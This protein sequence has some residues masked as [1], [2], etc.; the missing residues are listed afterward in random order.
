MLASILPALLVAGAALAAPAPGPQVKTNTCTSTSTK[1][2]EWSIID[3]D[4]HSSYIFSTPAHQNSWGYVNF[5]LQNPAVGYQ[6]CCS[7]SSNQLQD[8]FFGTVIYTCDGCNAPV[9]ADKTTFTFSRPTDE[10]FVNQTWNCAGEG[11]RF[12][13]QGGVVLNLTCADQSWQN[14]TWQQGQIYSTRNVDCQHVDAKVPIKA[15]SGIA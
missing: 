4:F 13:A 2:K 8:F 3:F 11:S 12:S 5:T 6:V 14:P 7:A 10:L 9:A 15:M 1:V